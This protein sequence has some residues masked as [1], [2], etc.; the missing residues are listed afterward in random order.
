MADC[1]STEEEEDSIDLLQ[2]AEYKLRESGR[3]VLLDKDKA[4]VWVF[5]LSQALDKGIAQ[6]LGLDGLE[7][8]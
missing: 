8:K 5:S 4:G 7:S 3:H 1:P 2:L 6:D